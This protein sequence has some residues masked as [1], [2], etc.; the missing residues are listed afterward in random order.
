MSYREIFE[1]TKDLIASFLVEAYG[2][3]AK[4]IQI[5]VRAAVLDGFFFDVI[6]E[7]G[8][9]ALATNLISYPQRTNPQPSVVAMASLNAPNN[10]TI[11]TA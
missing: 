2:C 11:G 4:A 5:G 6:H 1:L 10:S 3:K 9:V 8:S 7:L